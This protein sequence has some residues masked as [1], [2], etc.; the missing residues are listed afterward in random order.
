MKTTTISI[1]VLMTLFITCRSSAA[2]GKDD[3]RNDD[4]DDNKNDYA[5]YITSPKNWSHHDND[6]DQ[7]LRIFSKAGEVKYVP[8]KGTIQIPDTLRANTG[9]LREGS[10]QAVLMID[11]RVQ[12]TYSA[13]MNKKF[14]NSIYG[15]VSCTDGSRA[16]AEVRV[17]SKVGIYLKDVKGTAATLYATVKV[18]DRYVKGIKLPQLDAAKG[19]ILRFDGEL[20]VT[21]NYIPD[22]QSAGDVLLWDGSTWM[23]SKISGTA[24]AQGPQGPTGLTGSQGPQGLTGATGA[25]GAQGL[26]GPQGL[27]GATGATG[28]QGLS[29]PQGLTGA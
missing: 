18:S 10:S 8:F 13:S 28:A 7:T 11:G 23:A 4:R 1:L 16:R 29:G 27:T 24:G 19:Q 22:G 15:F 6:D 26:S 17:D 14:F 5:Y 25:T 9:L 20:W 2:F 3:D 12:C 21:S